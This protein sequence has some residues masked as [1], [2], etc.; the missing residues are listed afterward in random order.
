MKLVILMYLREDED[1]VDRLLSENRVP[2]YSRMEMEGVAKRGGGGWYGETAPYSSEM[3]VAVVPDDVAASLL[4]AVAECHGVQDPRHPIR[5]L[6]LPVERETA[7]R[8]E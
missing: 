7:C 1:C 2:V 5:A 3:I 8:C 4:D 6:Q